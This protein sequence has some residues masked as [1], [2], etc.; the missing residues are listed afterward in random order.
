MKSEWINNIGKSSPLTD[1]SIGSTVQTSPVNATTVNGTEVGVSK[2]LDDIGNIGSVINSGN[3]LDDSG[4]IIAVE[5]TPMYTDQIL[6][7]DVSL[8]AASEYG[9][10]MVMRIFG[11]EILNEG[12][13]VSVDDVSNEL[14]TTFLA[15]FISPWTPQKRITAVAR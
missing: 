4:N 2:L 3:I 12:S 5:E 1:A 8:V 11:V 15:R 14:Q 10:A 9:A 13:G 6:P 7:F